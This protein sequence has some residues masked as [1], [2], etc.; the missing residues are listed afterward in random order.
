MWDKIVGEL[1]EQTKRQWHSPLALI[2]LLFL[3]LILSLA[4]MAIIDVAKLSWPEITICVALLVAA[5]FIWHRTTRCPRPKK[6]NIGFVVAIGA[7]PSDADGRGALGAIRLIARSLGG[8][9]RLG[10]EP[11]LNELA[12]GCS[13]YGGSKVGPISDP[14][15]ASHLAEDLLRGC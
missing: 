15:P 9:E 14:T 8:V 4:L 10:E 11:Q 13:Q 12:F 5:S 7:E 6:G 1:L 2:M 3:T